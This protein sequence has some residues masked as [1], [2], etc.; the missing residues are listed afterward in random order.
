MRAVLTEKDE[1]LIKKY[2]ADY[3]VSGYEMNYADIIYLCARLRNAIRGHGT[4]AEDDMKNMM[5]LLFKLVLVLHYVLELEK[6]FFYVRH[7]RIG[8]MVHMERRWMTDL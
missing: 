4:V 2:L 5:I 3:E 7:M 6:M 8:Y 1:I